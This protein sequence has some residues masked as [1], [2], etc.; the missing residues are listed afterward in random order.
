LCLLIVA[1]PVYFLSDIPEVP[2]GFMYFSDYPHLLIIGSQTPAVWLDFVW[3]NNFQH[4][5]SKYGYASAI[6]S[7]GSS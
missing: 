4:P 6:Q 5:F 7:P 1:S 3:S 2:L